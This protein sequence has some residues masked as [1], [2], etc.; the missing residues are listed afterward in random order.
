MKKRAVYEAASFCWRHFGQKRAGLESSEIPARLAAPLGQPT[1]ANQFK[2]AGPPI[3][4][5]FR[6][7]Q[8]L[9]LNSGGTVSLPRH[10]R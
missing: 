9:M 6:L 4:P 2:H 3:V 1:T 5:V 10:D 8:A 7:T